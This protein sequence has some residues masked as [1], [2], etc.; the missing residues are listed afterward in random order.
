MPV[1]ELGLA[2]L[3]PTTSVELEKA[4]GSLGGAKIPGQHAS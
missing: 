1:G 2:G 4:G 3:A